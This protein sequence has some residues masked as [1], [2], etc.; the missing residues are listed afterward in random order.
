MKEKV[1]ELER[2][3][4]EA[5]KMGGEARLARQKERGKLDARARIGLLLDNGSFREIGLLGTHLGKDDPQNSTPA[6][7]V[8]CGSGL[9]DGR[10]RRNL[11]NGRRLIGRC[12]PASA[13]ASSLAPGAATSSRLRR[14]LL[15]RLRRRSRLLSTN[16]HAECH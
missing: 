16:S 5:K 1:E 11:R 9:I 8:V 10:P 6:D 14:L 2:R 13:G 7:G 3:R 4:A 15:R 12:A